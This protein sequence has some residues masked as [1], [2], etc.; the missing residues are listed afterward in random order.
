[1]WTLRAPRSWVDVGGDGLG[2]GD[3]LG[4]QAFAFEH[5]LEVHVAAD[6]ELVGAVQDHA[7][8]LEELGHHPVG[9][10]GADLGLDVVADDRD[11]GVGELL[12]PDGVGGDEHRQGVDEGD[13]GVDGALGVELVGGLGADR[14]VGDQDVDLVRP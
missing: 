4:L 3:L 11:A 5:V 2:L 8:V 9:D 13:A 7:A 1:M 14:E 12:G 6:V 10:G